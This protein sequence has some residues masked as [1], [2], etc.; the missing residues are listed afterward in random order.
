MT[1][2]PGLSSTGRHHGTGDDEFASLEVVVEFG[3]LVDQ[4]DDGVDGVPHYLEPGPAA[5]K[6]AVEFHRH[7]FVLKVEFF[8]PDHP[9]ANHH[10]AVERVVGNYVGGV[11]AVACHF[12]VYQL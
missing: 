1:E 11:N 8:E 7:P 12:Q 3:Q 6:A 4:P 9:G 10:P 5:V 2:S